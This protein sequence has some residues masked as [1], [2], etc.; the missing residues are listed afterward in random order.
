MKGLT[1]AGIGDAGTLEQFVEKAGRAG[2]DAVDAGGPELIEWTERAG[3]SG[4]LEALQ[5]HR[6]QIGAIGLGVEWR[7]DEE[8]FRD[9][10]KRL[11]QEAA[12]AAAVG[13]KVCCTYVLPSTDWN[14]ARFMAVATRRLRTCAV[15]L[16]AYGMKLGLEFVG[17]H[18]LRTAWRNP[19]VWDV[20]S[21]LEW[22]DAIGERNVGLL[23][24]SY[25]WYTNEL[26]L[27]DILKLDASLIAHVHINDAPNVP[28]QDALD[29]G[30]LYPGEGV[31]DLASFLR[32]LD[33][34]G[35]RGVVSQEILN[36]NPVTGTAEELI[37]RSKDAMDR[38]FRAAGLQ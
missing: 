10:L 15:V 24:D 18:H 16:G 31:I 19:F 20:D 5:Q 8:K 14:A 4:V 21:H 35:Y 13:C 22:I 27:D 36:K 30:R 11:A 6:V 17:P 2:F 34:I 1:R 12:A 28:V 26:G 32:G 33:Q 25:H 29:N 3:V 9:G 7:S 23:Y 37:R 38:V